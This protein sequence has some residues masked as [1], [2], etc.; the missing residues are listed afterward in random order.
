M[1]AAAA[2]AGERSEILGRWVWSWEMEEE[3]RE[4]LD[5]E[6]PGGGASSAPLPGKARSGC[7]VDAHP[8]KR[9]WRLQN[10]GLQRR[11]RRSRRCSRDGVLEAL[12]FN[13][14]CCVL[15]YKWHEMIIVL[16]PNTF[17]LTAMR[18]R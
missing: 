13:G 3:E 18:I 7:G 16:H 12:Y 1:R 8:L 10:T 6:E 17:R 4:R 15:D 5:E 2:A 9:L 11:S 14:F